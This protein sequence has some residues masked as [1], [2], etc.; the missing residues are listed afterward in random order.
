MENR[1]KKHENL[2]AELE[3]IQNNGIQ[4]DRQHLKINMYTQF[5][6]PF[7]FAREYVVNSYDAMATACYISGRETDN[8]VTLTISDNGRGM[9]GTRIRDYF[10]IFRSRKDN[11]EIKPIGHFGVGKM[12][13]AAVP[14]LLLFS[15]LTSTG[16]ECWRFETDTLTDDRAVVLEKIEPVPAGGTKFEI[17]FKKT[18]SLGQLLDKIYDILYIYVRHLDIDIYFD[19]PEL[20][21]DHNPIRKKLIK[22]NWCFDREN[23]GKAFTISLSGVPVEIMMG[24]GSAEHE[25]YQNRVYITSKYNLISY[26]SKEINIPNLKIR[27]NSEI[28]ELTFGR[29]CLSNEVVLK[30]IAGEIRDKILPEYFYFL[31]NHFSD[32]FV[33]ENPELA[34]KI[35]EMACSLIYFRQD[36]HPWSNFRLFNVH[37]FPRLSFNEISTATNKAGILYLEATDSEGSDYSIFGAPVLKTEQPKGGLALLQKYFASYIVNLN[38]TDVV[39]EATF[40]PDLILSPQEKHF[41]Q[42]LVFK[43]GY[44]ILNRLISDDNNNDIEN[45]RLRCEHISPSEERFGI[46]EEARIVQRDFSSLIWKVSYLMERDGI[47]P[48]KSRKF[49]FREGRV[50]LNLFHSEIRQ[51]IELSCINPKLAAHWAMAMCLSDMKLISHIT[52]EARE[53]LLLLDA[54]GRLEG[55]FKQTSE[56]W[57]KEDREYLDFLRYCS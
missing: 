19:L 1:N 46:C 44:E 43:P 8:T 39:I 16:E 51:F 11:G 25:L 45:S 4:S 26:G 33:V 36:V 18:V 32:R 3:K 54:M 28:F 20:D 27:V 9:D 49:M 23:L 6:D 56:P 21:N 7:E 17:K 34:D 15:G 37:C 14:D 47:T 29:H 12:S 57:A 30:D 5:S 55:E 22:G 10:K 2:A 52:P 40:R 53:D 41:E 48:C 42:F 31:R 24:L 38:E 13:V 35:E 50:V